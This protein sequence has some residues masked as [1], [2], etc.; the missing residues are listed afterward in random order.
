M[1]SPVFD[2][3]V[4]A[5]PISV[6]M[7]VLM[8]NIF[9]SSR[10]NQLFK[11]YSE[12]QYEQELLFSTIV[13]LMSLVV[14]GMYPSV[15]AA[16]QKKAV[17]I[18]VSA[19]AL[20]NKLQR[21]ELSVSRALLHE[22][23]SDLQQLLES[24]NV[25]RPSPLG[26]EYR[27]RIIDGS[28][29]AGT[30]RRLSALRSVPAKPLPGKTIAILDPGIKLVIDVIPCED[31]HAQE[32]SLFNQIL[33]QV[34]PRQVWIADRNF[35]TAGFLHT[36]AQLGAFF[37]IRQHGGLGYKPVSELQAVGLCQTGTVFEQQVEIVNE[38]ETFQCR[39]IIVKL[40]SPTRDQ[41]WEIAIFT[42]LPPTDADG[43]LVAEIYQG[44]WSVETLFQTVTQNF[45][46]EIE[47]L[48]YPKAALFSYCMALSAYNLL[49]TLKAV[50]G[51]VHGVDK[52]EAGLSDF[53]LVDDIHGIYRGMMIA[54]PP[55]HWQCF[56]DF[57]HIQMLDVL[58][59]LAT[60]VH[61]KSFRKH[62]RSP[63]KKQPPLSFDA[64]HPHCSTARKLKQYKAALDAIP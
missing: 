50:L 22:T 53:Y 60:K 34:Q 61:L 55:V 8:E 47:T 27:Q 25:E 26:K 31:G 35:C 44:R 6:M 18:S 24:L 4:E 29:L 37:V 62:P 10:M 39:R 51:S 57:T 45:N 36:I 23:A 11:T 54:I 56:E 33:A 7:R 52:I 43:I 58:Q 59:H 30:E 48:A 46:G 63:K 40:A 13:D 9:N 28:C 32:R 17:D 12:R 5:S 42:N 19:T 64:K 41:E 2:A 21:I 20:Y 16:Y 49:A 38:G 3:F 15:H 14:C 1:L